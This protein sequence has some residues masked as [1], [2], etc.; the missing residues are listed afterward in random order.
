VVN[1][2]VSVCTLQTA[3]HAMLLTMISHNHK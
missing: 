2:A 3:M 1:V